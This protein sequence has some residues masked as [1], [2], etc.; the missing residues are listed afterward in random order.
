VYA[1]CETFLIHVFVFVCPDTP[2]KQ[3]QL[4]AWQP[5]IAWPDYIYVFILL[6][7]VFIPMGIVFLEQSSHL[8][9][10]IMTYD[11]SSMDVPCNITSSNEG[12]TCEVCTVK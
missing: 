11:G 7:I 10:Y 1:V 9:E 3:Q 12:N 8:Q 2:F 5:N 4:P 6:G